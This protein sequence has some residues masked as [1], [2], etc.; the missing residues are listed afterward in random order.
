[1]NER[2]R[3]WQRV[4]TGGQDEASQLPDLISWCDSHAY[5]YS[6]TDAYVVRGRSAW[7]GRH[8]DTLDRAFADMAAGQYVVLVVWK[9][10]RIERRGME[11]ALN[12]ISRAKQAG[13]RIE[14]A[15]QPHLNKLNDM[16][17][18]ISYAIMAEVAQAESQTKSDRVSAKH[19]ALRDAGS[20]VGRSPWGYR[21]VKRDGRKILE[22]T[23]AGRKFIPAIF[24]AVINGKNLR[25]VAAW[26]DSEG[27]KPTR[28]GSWNESFLARVISNPTYYGMRPN[29]PNLKYE[30]LVSATTWQAANAALASR[31][32]TGRGTVKHDK[33]LV[34]PF[35]GVCYGQERDGC[36]S[37][38][39][40]MYRT[41]SKYADGI[42]A[43]FR[44]NGCGPQ[45]KPCGAP[46]LSVAAVE[47]AVMEAMNVDYPHIERVF[48]PGD[49]TADRIGELQERGAAAIRAGDY[50]A[51]TEAMQLAAEL[52]AGPSV[53][54]HWEERETD[55]TE[56]EYFTG[57]SRDEQRDY[58]A[59]MTIVAK[60]DEDG[61][62]RVGHADLAPEGTS[63]DVIVR[64]FEV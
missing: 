57:L 21:I 15:T 37:G 1:M 27:A 39:S 13:G 43:M 3:L 49:D 64:L 18:R 5:S 9:Q 23:E 25:A 50:V 52:D 17:G 10:D 11:A 6:L 35:C 28:R 2:A 4:S 59:T 47:T 51:A 46:M 60:L 38:K 54:A 8:Q 56:A 44:C 30:A 16:G 42:R 7:H 36:P 40:P 48:I 34:R 14:F 58:L 61:N 41:F 20:I 63:G 24:D 45:S 62:V 55:I 26:L 31:V 29:S 53:P 19:A 12:L 33:P 22:P 32:R